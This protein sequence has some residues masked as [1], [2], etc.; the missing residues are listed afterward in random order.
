MGHLIRIDW[1]IKPTPP[2]SKQP[3]IKY[4]SSKEDKSFPVSVVLTFESRGSVLGLEETNKAIASKLQESPMGW[5]WY[6][7][8]NYY[9]DTRFIEGRV[10]T[11]T[12]RELA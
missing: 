2:N 1:S 8:N 4:D 10:C 9:L 6:A 5:I 12:C 11:T 3:S 7:N